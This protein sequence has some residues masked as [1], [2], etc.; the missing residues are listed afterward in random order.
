MPQPTA[1]RSF[2]AS[3]PPALWSNA[4]CG[5]PTPNPSMAFGF[6]MTWEMH[7][8]NHLVSC[9]AVVLEH[10]YCLTPRDRDYGS[11]DAVVRRGPSAAAD[12]SES[13]S[14]VSAGSLGM[15]SV[16]PVLS[17]LMS[18]NASTLSSS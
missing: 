16:C 10:V 17:G 9:R 2:A 13:R 6:G 8:R 7:V 4:C 1:A 5:Q 15:T 12:S 3:S 11:A 18:R 14:I